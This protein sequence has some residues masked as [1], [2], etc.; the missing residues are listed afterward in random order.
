MDLYILMKNIY[1]SIL[2]L[3][4]NAFKLHIK[5]VGVSGRVP[6]LLASLHHLSAYDNQ[7][8]NAF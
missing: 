3:T 4:V 5:E 2:D 6:A 7:V 8:M 1:L